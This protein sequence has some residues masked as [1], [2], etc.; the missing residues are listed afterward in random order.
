MKIVRRLTA[1][2]RER[3][4]Q[5]IAKI[6]RESNVD[7]HVVVTPISDRYA[8][9]P[10]VGAGVGA[11]LAAAIAALVRPELDSRTVIF[12]QLAVLIVLTLIFDWR[13]L[14][15]ALVP[16]RIKHAHARQLAHRAFT[17]HLTNGGTHPHKILLFTSI[18]EHYVEIIADHRTHTMIS[19]AAWNRIVAQFT[20]AANSGQVADGLLKAVEACAEALGKPDGSPSIPYN[21]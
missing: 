13:P 2:E 3:I 15:L 9:Y 11:L 8:L 19:G 10:L 4:G 21:N 6:G 14:R 18:A 20:T 16:R 7:F 5:A 12:L 1:A 17:A